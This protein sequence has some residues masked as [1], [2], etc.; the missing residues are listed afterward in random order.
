MSGKVCEEDPPQSAPCP[1]PGWSSTPERT[2][3][4]LGRPVFSEARP[5]VLSL[6]RSS[7]EAVRLVE[8]P[9]SWLWAVTP[10]RAGC[11][12]LGGPGSPAHRWGW[13]LALFAGSLESP[14]QVVEVLL[15]LWH[16]LQRAEGRG[17]RCALAPWLPAFP[18]PGS[19]P[20]RDAGSGPSRLPAFRTPRA[21][22][23]A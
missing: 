1:L 10:H 15:V 22:G 17:G 7:R 5:G 13:S 21:M 2:P 23:G 12:Y 8:R 6:G 4:S 11:R 14:V 18:T 3:Y 20:S 19:V 16:L 9:W